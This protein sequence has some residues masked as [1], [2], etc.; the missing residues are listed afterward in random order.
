MIAAMWFTVRH[1]DATFA[2]E[3]KKH[4]IFDFKVPG[5]AAATFDVITDP[6]GL[7]RWMPDLE[8]AGWASAPPHGV[9]S[10][11]EVRL[12]T[13]AVHERVLVWEPG[14]RFV[15]TIVKA[16]A[17]IVRRMVEDYRLEPVSGGTRVQWTI[18]YQPTLVATP[19]EP[20]LRKRFSKMFER[21]CTRLTQYLG[22]TTGRG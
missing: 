21:A 12:R 2:A 6:T 13:V 17:P 19:L 5:P 14:E 4:F 20:I 15:F 22:S 7:G 11:R 9:G 18:A 16:S 10:V 1:A 8:R 3:A